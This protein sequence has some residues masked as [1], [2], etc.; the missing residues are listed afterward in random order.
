LKIYSKRAFLFRAVSDEE[1]IDIRQNGL[2]N[3]PGAYETGKLFAITLKEASKFGKNN[4]LL[5]DLCNTLIKAEVPGEIYFS[6][7]KFEADGMQA[8]LIEKECLNLLKISVLSY[9]PVV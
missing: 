6:S 2:R 5:D 7:V 1:L 8:V 3:K 4:F 9:S